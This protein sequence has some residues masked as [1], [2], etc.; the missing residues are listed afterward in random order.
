MPAS[1]KAQQKF[2]GMVHALQ[3]SGGRAPSKAVAKAAGSMKPSDVKD[4]ASTKRKGL[5]AKKEVIGERG[6]PQDLNTWI[7]G[8]KMSRSQVKSVLDFLV[9]LPLQQLRKRQDITNQQIKI[10][11]NQKNIEALKNLQIMQKLLDAA[12]DQQQFGESAIREY[13]REAIRDVLTEKGYTFEA[14]KS[15]KVKCMECGKKFKSANLAPTCPK[16]GSGD[17]DLAE[18]V[19][20]SWKK[21]IPRLASCPGMS[22][23]AEARDTEQSD[24]EYIKQQQQKKKMV[25]ENK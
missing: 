16:C 24:Q 20:G 11:Y 1:S 13:I 8:G 6:I 14:S 21:E 19:G 25:G 2:M 9:K 18:S 22:P 5:P 7:F 17:I 12:I 4:F 15:I 10:A 3:K 23:E